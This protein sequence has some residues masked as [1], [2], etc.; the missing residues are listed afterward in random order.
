MLDPALG[1]ADVDRLAEVTAGLKAIQ[2]KAILTARAAA[3]GRRGAQGNLVELSPGASRPEEIIE[4]AEK[5]ATI[6]QGMTQDEIRKL[7]APDGKPPPMAD[8][9]AEI[10]RWWPRASARSSSASAS[11]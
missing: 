4:R 8:A 2:I 10:D 9:R 1:L 5:L 3:R 11:A 7:I 6:T